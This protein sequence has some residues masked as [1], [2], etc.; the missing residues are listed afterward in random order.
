MVWADYETIPRMRS[1]EFIRIAVE[2]FLKELSVQR[3]LEI[4]N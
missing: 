3:R 1:G 2:N 4:L